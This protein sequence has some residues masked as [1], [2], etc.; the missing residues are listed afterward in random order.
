MKTFLISALYIAFYLARTSALELPEL[1]RPVNR[2]HAPTSIPEWLKG[3]ESLLPPVDPA[4]VKEMATMLNYWL[5][6]SNEGGGFVPKEYQADTDRAIARIAELQQTATEAM[7]WLYTYEGPHFEDQQGRLIAELF[8]D[9]TIQNYSL[10]LL[11]RKLAWMTEQYERKNKAGLN[12][13][14]DVDGLV[15]YLLIWG[16]AKDIDALRRFMQLLNEA[17]QEIVGTQGKKL[18]IIEQFERETE[19]PFPGYLKKNNLRSPRPTWK[20]LSMNWKILYG[21]EES[22]KYAALYPMTTAPVPVKQP[23]APVVVAPV[24]T[25]PIP[26]SQDLR[27]LFWLLA[28]LAALGS[29]GWLVNK[30]TK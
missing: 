1:P 28:V 20:R 14:G 4:V 10:P 21:P 7:L 2:F 9:P 27:W 3:H 29:L 22:A 24:K 15:N 18:R 13:V 5:L 23:A 25:P 12:T 17:A 19:G 16:D 6:Y 11:R 8:T 30:K 26:E